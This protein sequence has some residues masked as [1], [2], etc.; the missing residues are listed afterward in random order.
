M[1][2]ISEKLRKPIFAFIP[3]ENLGKV[4]NLETQDS[5]SVSVTVRPWDARFLGNEK[6]SAAQKRVTWG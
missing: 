1:W 2:K 6:T 3:G 4:F 5:K